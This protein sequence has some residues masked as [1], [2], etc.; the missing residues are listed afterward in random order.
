MPPAEAEPILLVALV[1]DVGMRMLDYDRL[2]TKRNLSEEEISILKEHVS[3][4][5]ALVKPLLGE[6]V[7]R[8]VL[9]HHERVDGRGYPNELQG[10]EIPY[11]SRVLQICDAY[12]AMTN[13]VYQDPQP[14]EEVLQ[15]IS[16]ASGSQFDPDLTKRFL[17]M[18]GAQQQTSSS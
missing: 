8:A 10:E 14:R 12:V 11:S 2:Y 3:I 15:T 1:H 6:E 9:S 16:L 4:G 5:A 18:M 17:E 7:S 13:P